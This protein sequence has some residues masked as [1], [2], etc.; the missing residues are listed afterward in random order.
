MHRHDSRASAAQ[1][2]AALVKGIITSLGRRTAYAVAGH[3]PPARREPFL[4]FA[5]RVRGAG[6]A[7]ASRLPRIVP[8]R[9]R[10]DGP[11]PAR[12]YPTNFRVPGQR[13]AI[14]DDWPEPPHV[15]DPGAPVRSVYDRGASAPAYDIDLFEQ[16]NAEYADKP[17]VP[18]PPGKD[19]DS[20]AGRARERMLGLH[21]ALDLADKRVL[22]IG[23]G[24]G[25]EVWYLAHH[26]GADAYG[27]DVMSR[28]AWNALADERTHFECA[29][30]T[31]ANPF[32][33]SFFDRVLSFTVWEH[34]THPYALLREMHRVMK[35]GGLAWM[36][37]NLH[38]SAVASHLYREIFFPYP[39]L[40]FSDEV[41]RE[42][43]RR[44]GEHPRGPSWVNHVT[45]AQY[46]R[47]FELVGFRI[48]MLRFT[49]RELDEE[50]YRRFEDVLGRY[51]R[52]DLT[53]DFFTVVLEKPT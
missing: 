7:A 18:A 9:D 47:Y 8:S 10:S 49:E 2:L 44:R 40:L 6:A 12:A 51:P 38:R 46:E 52:F 53:K 29:D 28:K 16:L 25:Y 33:E 31:V 50:F 48:R 23:C 32:P 13:A 15:D 5:R 36:R 39:H 19:A 17:V 42:F 21:R 30:M 26:F 45:W 14:A 22:E 37:A 20:R 41:I 3:L 24:A 35:P 34:V 11:A 27:I 4:A 1:N 43:Y